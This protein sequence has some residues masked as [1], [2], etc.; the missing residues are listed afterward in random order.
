[1]LEALR[2]E[3]S[4]THMLVAI[5]SACFFFIPQEAGVQLPDLARVVSGLITGIGFLGA[6]A[7][8]KA[9][10]ES[11]IHGL[12]T[13]ASIWLTAAIGMTVGMGR[14]SSAVVTTILSLLVLAPLSRLDRAIDRSRERSEGAQ[15]GEGRERCDR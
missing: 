4:D 2:H 11:N 15:S 13:A 3:F 6:G 14:V 1:M 8:F 12:T 7:I 5:G 9:D 10:G